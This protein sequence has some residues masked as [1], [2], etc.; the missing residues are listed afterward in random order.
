MRVESGICS[1]LHLDLARMGSNSDGC[2]EETCHTTITIQISV[3]T[4]DLLSSKTKA[5]ETL[6]HATSGGSILLSVNSSHDSLFENAESKAIIRSSY[7]FDASDGIEV[8]PSLS[9]HGTGIDG[10]CSLKA[11]PVM[12]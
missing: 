5:C 4:G 9:L 11:Q 10:Q 3:S 6:Q 2:S 12:D 7:I 8:L 1:L